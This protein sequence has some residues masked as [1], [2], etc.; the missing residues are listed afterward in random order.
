VRKGE[1][2]LLVN[3][4]LLVKYSLLANQEEHTVLAT[5]DKEFSTANYGITTTPSVEYNLVVKG[6]MVEGV[7]VGGA[8]EVK[9]TR[10]SK[11]K[12]GVAQ[13]DERVLRPL[14]DYGVFREDGR[15]AVMP[16]GRVLV[17]EDFKAEEVKEEEEEEVKEVKEEEVTKGAEGTV[18]EI[19]AQD[20]SVTVDFQG[21]KRRGKRRVKK[22]EVDKLHPQPSEH[23]S[24]VQVTSQIFLTR[25]ILLTDHRCLATSLTYAC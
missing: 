25:Q 11:S 4:S 3:Y 2:S 19:N 10:R 22:A 20:G 12:G 21:G 5:C 8:V 18:V 7:G 15:L 14:G 17:G 24:P 1:D 9:G 16:G 13:K 6:S 23:D